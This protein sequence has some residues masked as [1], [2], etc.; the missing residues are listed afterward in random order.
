MHLDWLCFR[1]IVSTERV[2]QSAHSSLGSSESWVWL[3]L[4]SLSLLSSLSL[5]DG[6]IPSPSLFTS[7]GLSPGLVLVW[8]NSFPEFFHAPSG[9]PTDLVLPWGNSFPELHCC[10]LRFDLASS[11][12]SFLGGNVP[13]PLHLVPWSIRSVQGLFLPLV[14]PRELLRQCPASSDNLR[15]SPVVCSACH[16]S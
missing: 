10:S 5:G 7:S 2:Q 11:C 12:F 14:H 16:D 6:A 1:K 15:L 9:L 3:L 13:P 4:L 8:G